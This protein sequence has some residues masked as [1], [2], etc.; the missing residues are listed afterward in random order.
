M[1]GAQLLR[2]LGFDA[3]FCKICEGVNR[4]SEQEKEHKKQSIESRKKLKYK[5]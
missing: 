5:K 4:Y 2:K 3:R 1:E